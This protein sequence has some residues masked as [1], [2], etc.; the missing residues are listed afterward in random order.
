MEAKLNDLAG[1]PENQQ[2]T[3]LSKN[4]D[5]KTNDATLVY[6]YVPDKT[7]R[8]VIVRWVANEDGLCHLEMATTGLPQDKAALLAVLD[9]ATETATRSDSPL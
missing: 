6:T 5:A 2:V 7:V 8:H 9:R 4:V 1:V 3:I